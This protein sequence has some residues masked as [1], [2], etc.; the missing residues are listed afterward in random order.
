[1]NT[2]D[3]GRRILQ[4]VALAGLLVAG[5]AADA[6]APGPLQTA[7]IYGAAARNGGDGRMRNGATAMSSKQE[8]PA[9][10]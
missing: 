8:R 2:I 3:D 7:K 10:T 5:A 9:E 6:A 4:A 1:M